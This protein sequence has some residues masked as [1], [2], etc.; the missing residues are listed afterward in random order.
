MYPRRKRS[1]ELSRGEIARGWVFFLLYLFVF[2]V[3]M[4]QLQALLS[5]RFHFFLQS[6]EFSLIYYFVLLCAALV[7]FWG[8]LR[9]GFDA[10][11]DDLPEN[12][13]ALILGL[14]GAG[15]L[16]FLAGLLPLPEDPYALAYREQFAAAP[17]ATVVVLVVLMP[18]LEELLFRGLLY[19][20]L[21][22]YSRGLACAA[23]VVGYLLF[24]TLP[25]VFSPEG[26]QPSYLLLAV[27]YLPM[28]AVLT[29]CYDYGGSIWSA[30]GLHMA[31]NAASL[32]LAL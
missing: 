8:L 12:L 16:H 30:A 1:T 24:L 29:W 14:V 26:F 2:P 28:S 23:S 19:G 3:L 10:L 4:G 22:W 6:A 11:L 17:A 32:L 25:L 20:S 18:L 21:R 27:W 15:A 7:L 9:R 31:L 5:L 13:L